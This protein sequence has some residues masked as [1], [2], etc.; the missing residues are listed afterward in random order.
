[1]AASSRTASTSVDAGRLGM[2]GVGRDELVAIAP[3]AHAI[4][5]QP[6]ITARDLESDPIV[7]YDR[8][9]QITELTLAFL[10]EEGVFPRVA[11][12]IDH[13][14]AIKRLVLFACATSI[15]SRD[16]ALL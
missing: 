1:M 14:E 9:S 16:G 15:D 8:E 7:L 3:P 12:E 11:V 13:L 4:A 5:G 2:V 10:L 6:W